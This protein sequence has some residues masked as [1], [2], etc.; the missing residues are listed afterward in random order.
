MNVVLS[1]E[2]PCKLYPM[3]FFLTYS[4][5][6]E[7]DLSLLDRVR[8]PVLQPFQLFPSRT[9]VSKRQWNEIAEKRHLRLLLCFRRVDCANTWLISSSALV[10]CSVALLCSWDGGAHRGMSGVLPGACAFT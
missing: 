1:I 9:G 2:S 10:V 8:F 3:Y 5:P 6:D 4:C 7:E